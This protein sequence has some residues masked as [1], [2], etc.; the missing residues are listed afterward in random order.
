VARRG[1]VIDDIEWE[2][3]DEVPHYEVEYDLNG[4][5]WELKVTEDGR[6]LRHER[7]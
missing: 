7:D 4:E 1:G 6:V 5:E 2:A 3:K